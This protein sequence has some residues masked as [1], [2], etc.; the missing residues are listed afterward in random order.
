[1]PEVRRVQK[2]G[3]S[4]L[5][6]SLPADWVKVVGLKAGDPVS[7]ELNE[8]G[9]LRVLPLS[10]ASKKVEKVVKLVINK[11]SDEELITRSIYATYLL[12]YDKV[13]IESVDGYLMDTQF[14]SIR[15]IAKTLIGVEI[16]EQL[17]DKLVLQ[18]FVDPSKYS[19]SGLLN[20]MGNILRYMIQYFILGIINKQTHLLEEV[21]E[22][23]VEL[24][25]LYAL[26]VRQLLLSQLDRS[27]AKVLGIKVSLI[28]EFRTIAKALEDSGDSIDSATQALLEGGTEVLEKL[29]Q[30]TDILR[31]SLDTLTLIIDR[32][33]RSL[34]ESNLLTI[35][36]TI[37]LINEFF[38]H[39]EKYSI[40][41]FRKLGLDETYLVIRE[42]LDK[43][44][45]VAKNFETISEIAYDMAIEKQRAEINLAVK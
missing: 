38:K 14:K 1:M 17:P 36:E 28:T 39:V 3:R 27:L 45:L 18:V 30:I 16:V 31:E 37:N 11:L 33:M 25:R 42:L 22:L 21:R 41:L 32:T 10:I 35:N 12:G 44:T 34:G 19:V 2:F 23:E 15:K 13:I 4:T 6:V 7:I 8:D 43:L 29:T 9:S 40:M 26:T 24:D 20:R 5:M